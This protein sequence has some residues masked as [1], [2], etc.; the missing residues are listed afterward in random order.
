MI[1]KME[2]RT[3][4]NQGRMDAKIEDNNGTLLG[5]LVSRMVVHQARTEANMEVWIERTEDYVGKLESIEK[6]RNY[7]FPSTVNI[8]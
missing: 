8:F 1:G 3:R 2:D 6:S 7:H 5:T 4:N